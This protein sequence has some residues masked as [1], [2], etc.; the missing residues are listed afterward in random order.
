MTDCGPVVWGRCVSCGEKIDTRT[1]TERLDWLSEETRDGYLMEWHV[2][3]CERFG[4]ESPD[5]RDAI[6]VAMDAKEGD[7]E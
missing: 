4:I 3:L 1:D 2:L 6:D 7:G 5:I